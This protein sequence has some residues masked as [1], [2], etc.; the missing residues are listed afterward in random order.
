MHFWRP[1]ALLLRDQVRLTCSWEPLCV[2]LYLM[3]Q[4]LPKR[5]R[6][7]QDLRPEKLSTSWADQE[8]VGLTCVDQFTDEAQVAS[9]GSWNNSPLPGHSDTGYE[10]ADC[11]KIKGQ[12]Y[13][14]SQWKFSLFLHLL[15]PICFKATA[16]WVNLFKWWFHCFQP[17][18]KAQ[19]I[20]SELRANG[21]V[22]S[23][24]IWS[25]CSW[26]GILIT[27]ITKLD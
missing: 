13:F 16:K 18:R 17:Q 26:C 21:L 6:V 12:V 3:Q 7:D 19:P 24:N 4:L 23:L 1:F 11:D 20:E 22:I 14:F 10:F 2:L 9:A 5:Q 15:L 8:L 25:K 27:S